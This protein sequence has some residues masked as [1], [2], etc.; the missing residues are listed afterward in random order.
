MAGISKEERLARLHADALAEFDEIQEAQREI[1]LQCLEDRRF[2]SI[3]G[4]QWEGALGDQFEAK[5]QFEFNKTHLAVIRIFN[6]YRNN[7]ITVDFEAKDGS[8]DD[9]LADTCDGLYRADEQACTA[10]EAYDN[11]FEEGV[12]GGFGAWRLRTE[13]EDEYDDENTNQR[14]CIDPIF[15]ADSCV[16]F[17]LGAKRQ[18]KSDAKRCFV[19]T[20]Y[21][22]RGYEDTFGASAAD[23]ASSWQKGVYRSFYDWYTPKLIWICEMYVVEESHQLVHFYRGLDESMPEKSY[24]DDELNSDEELEN[25]LDA[26]GYREVRQKKTARRRIHKYIMSGARVMSDEGYI[27]GDQ[28]PI[29]PFFGKRWV[30]DGIERCMGHVRL[31]KDAQRLTNMLLSWL[32]DIAARFDVEKP[33]LTPEQVAG[34]A[35]MWAEDNFSRF[36]YLLVNSVED[37]AGNKIMPNQLQYTKAPNVPPAMAALAEMAGQALDDM[38]G[39]QQAGEQLQPNLSGKAVELIQNRLDMQVY[40]Y[41]SNLA[42]A[43]KRCGEIWLSMKRDTVTEDSRQMKVIDAAGQSSSVVMNQPMHDPATGETTTKNDLSKAS[44]DITPNVGPS[45]S[46]KRQATVRVLS[47]M[48]ATTQDPN[49]ATILNSLIMM[50]MEGEGVDDAREYFRSQLV[51]QGVIKPTPQEAQ[52][53]QAAASNQQPDPNSQYLQAAASQADAEAAQARAKTVDTIADAHLKQAQ[54]AKTYAEAAAT[55]MGAHTDH[56]MALHQISQPQDDGQ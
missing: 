32:A 17:D 10:E 52:E 16:F 33:I 23:D 14:I 13:Y 4:A 15:D 36:P 34:H 30:I 49:T 39:N 51:K 37:E 21:T 1:R 5:P 35:T 8:Q 25:E 43:M 40:I 24:T 7:R 48:L 26:T 44:F 29:V 11:A 28:I 53:L 42:K 9:E 27:A 47:A 54:Q 31:A 56:L 46:S 41:M 45:S 6:E 3:A 55:H 2:Y 12:A 18:D 20:P 19:L 50:N 22:Y 38:L